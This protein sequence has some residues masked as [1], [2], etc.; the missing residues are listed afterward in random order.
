MTADSKLKPNLWH[1]K[2]LADFSVKS[3]DIHLL[4]LQALEQLKKSEQFQV[5]LQIKFKV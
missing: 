3:Q 1:F 4:K 2:W 5:Q